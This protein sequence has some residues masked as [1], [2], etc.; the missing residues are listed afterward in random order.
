MS[1]ARK[2]LYF[3]CFAGASGDMILGALLDLG[4]DLEALKSELAKLA[5]PGYR[6]EAGKI[7]KSGF[8]ATKFNVLEEAGPHHDHSHG[9]NLSDI[10]QIIEE[11]RLASE[12]KA[13]SL[14]IFHRLAAAEAKI[15]GTTP[16]K[17]HFHE[18]G[19]VDAIVDIVGAVIGLHLLQVDKIVV[20][21]LP[22]GR[23]FVRCQHGTIPLPAP[24]TIELLGGMSVYGA[25][26]D[27]ET[28]TPTGAAILSTLAAACGLMPALQVHKVGYGAGT[29][30]FSV[31]NLLRAVLGE[32]GPARSDGDSSV[33]TVMELEANIDDM[34][35]ELFDF[36]FE[37]LFSKGALD[38]FLAPV[39][40][41]KNRPANIIR[42]LCAEK[43]LHELSGVLFRETTT[44]GVRFK[45]WQRLCLKR[46]V[47]TVETEFGAI[48][49]KQAL[50][51]GEIVNSAPEYDDC[52]AK[53]IQLGAPVKKV[54]YAAMRAVQ[55]NQTK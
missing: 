46:E 15:H 17:I 54:Y 3:D 35:P 20:S 13:R 41:K 6:L 22:M 27:G 8:G 16:D 32:E 52:K 30:D 23:G 14:A 19:A 7:V 28:V 40:M 1:E 2:V 11:S 25:D 47:V 24:A 21:P 42:V 55:V 12:I 38:V 44:I 53:A 31:P 18:V 9:R 36:V 43:D 37:Q 50:L 4:L 49:I 26:F 29:R 5:L 10:T 33:E 39:Q 34:N 51:D 48:R 45:T